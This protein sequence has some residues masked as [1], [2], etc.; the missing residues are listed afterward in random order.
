MQTEQEYKQLIANCR[1]QIIILEN[2]L[3]AIDRADERYNDLVVK[4]AKKEKQMIILHWCLKICT[5]PA[6]DFPL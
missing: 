3:K 5:Q 4:L 2:E 1:M 6:K